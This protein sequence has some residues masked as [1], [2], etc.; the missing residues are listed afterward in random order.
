[1]RAIAVVLGILLAGCGASPP[2]IAGRS[3]TPSSTPTS[4]PILTA[5]T[6][7]GARVWR[8]V[9][10]QLAF[11]DL[12]LEDVVW[13]GERF[14]AI[15]GGPGGVFLDSTD[16]VTWH[17]QVSPDDGWSPSALS[18]GG[19]L[20]VAVG[21]IGDRAASWT[22][23]DGLTWM[24]SREAGTTAKQ[25]ARGV[26]R[27]TATP[28]GWL[29]VGTDW[30]DEPCASF[31]EPDMARSSTSEDGM[32]WVRSTRQASI[33]GAEFTDAAAFG[34]VFYAGGRRHFEA[35]LW[36]SADGLAWSRVDVAPAFGVSLVN[37]LPTT[38]TAMAAKP[39]QLVVLG[40]DQAQDTEWGQRVWAWSSVDGAAWSEDT[41]EGPLDGQVFDATTTPDR[42]LAVGPS[43][44]PGCHSGIWE[45]TDAAWRCISQPGAFEGFAPYAVASSPTTDVVVGFTSPDD[46][47]EE[48]QAP[49][50]GTVWIR[51]RS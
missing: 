17:R 45:K 14:V 19:G 3:P 30:T 5:P 23:T 11:A 18:A 47:E 46:P 9:P 12:Q 48:D 2:V 49:A 1:M 16:G 41:V 43:G 31:C 34:G 44:S 7:A 35:R 42:F 50:V 10:Q 6:T 25:D 39:D 26:D 51:P 29:S 22:S 33:E 24:T 21:S 32:R 40:I 13:T 8:A 15:Q 28:G 36:R 37:D 27:V 20:V 38:V 4:T